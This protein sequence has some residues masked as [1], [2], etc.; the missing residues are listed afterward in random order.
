MGNVSSIIC[1]KSKP[2]KRKTEQVQQP[3]EKIFDISILPFEGRGDDIIERTEQKLPRI[4]ECADESNFSTPAK[5]RGGR[6]DDKENRPMS[7]QSKRI[8]VQEK[9]KKSANSYLDQV[10]GESV[11]HFVAAKNDVLEKK[12][13]I[14][15]LVR[16]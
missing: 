14:N 1:T 2:R 15:R 12:R 7:S 4:I 5:K 13:S 6:Q 8:N 9:R 11:K 3:K 16:S 10:Y